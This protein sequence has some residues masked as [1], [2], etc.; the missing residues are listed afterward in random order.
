MLGWLASNV[1]AS[2]VSNTLAEEQSPEAG[3]I[4]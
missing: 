2:R 1:S 3:V 4:F